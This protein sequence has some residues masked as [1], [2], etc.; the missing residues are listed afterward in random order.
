MEAFH[1]FFGE[2]SGAP[3]YWQYSQSNSLISKCHYSFRCVERPGLVIEKLLNVLSLTSSW[4]TDELSDSN[5][6]NYF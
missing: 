6:L 5:G 2:F 3:A 4:D 1:Q